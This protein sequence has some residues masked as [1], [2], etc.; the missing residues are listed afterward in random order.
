MTSAQVVETPVTNNSSFQ[1]YPHPNDQ[2]M[3]TNYVLLLLD[4]NHLLRYV[5][6]YA[7]LLPREHEIHT[8]EV[9]KTLL[10]GVHVPYLNRI[11]V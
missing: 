1:N 7:F 4:S 10:Y 8:V 5:Y 11:R 3:H 9:H 6:M 2:T